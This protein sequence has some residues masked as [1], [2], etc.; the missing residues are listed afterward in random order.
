MWE[1]TWYFYKVL[2]SK[3]KYIRSRNE[4]IV[5]SSYLVNLSEGAVA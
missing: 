1:T 5:S 2:W 4:S 3:Q